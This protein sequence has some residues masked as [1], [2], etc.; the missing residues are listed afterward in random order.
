VKLVGPFAPHLGDEAWEKLGE[1]G[2]L[3]AAAWPSFDP[4]L[5]IDAVVT[6][7][8][9]VNGKMRGSLEVARDAA[10]EEIRKQALAVP[11]VAKH[12]EGKTVRKVIVV[13]GRIVNI[14][15]G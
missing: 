7:A 11:N 6:L 14:V 2:F 9:Q 8:I 12:I 3:V 15:V 4:A 13:P 10:E 1:K 5:T